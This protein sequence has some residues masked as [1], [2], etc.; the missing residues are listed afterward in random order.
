MFNRRAKQRF[1]AGAGPLAVAVLAAFFAWP[2]MGKA[3]SEQDVEA[4]KEILHTYEKR[5]EQL[6][7]VWV[8]FHTTHWESLGWRRAAAPHDVPEEIRWT[9]ENDFA[10][11]GIKRRSWVKG[12]RP[13]P[14]KEW[15]GE[16][17]SY[18]QRR[19]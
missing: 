4:L 13:T 7:P 6:N 11:K 3:Q 12:G 2:D 1:V 9:E 16:Q 18:L 17:L 19:S 10:C 8:R 15:D 14:T 5:E